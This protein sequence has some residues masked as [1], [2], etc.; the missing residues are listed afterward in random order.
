MPLSDFPTA[1]DLSQAQ[2]R[3][4]TE[5]CWRAVEAQHVVSTMRLV[6][7][8]PVRQQLLEE[9]LEQSKPPRPAATAQLHYLLATP[10]RYPPSQHGSRFR[11]WPDAGVLY[12]ARHQRTACAEMGYWRWRF[13]TASEGLTEIPAAAQ[14]LFSLGAAGVTLDL[15]RAPLD[16]WRALWTQPGD[17]THTQQLG[18]AA[19]E[20]GTAIVRYESV[21]DPQHGACFAILT[22]SAIRPLQP[23]ARET[24]YLTVTRDGVVWQREAGQFSFTYS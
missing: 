23:T 12:A 6:D 21:R 18:R 13:L 17:Y 11:R 1:E 14:M 5:T 22:P 10:F 3:T 15:T 9:I 7:N 20:A 24:W 16:A 19:R 4:R 2:R 8:D